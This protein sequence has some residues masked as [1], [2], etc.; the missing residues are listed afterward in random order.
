MYKQRLSSDC[1]D[2]QA[3]VSMA[4]IPVIFDTFASLFNL[5]GFVLTQ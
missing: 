2:E 4:D 1:A 3:D 5:Q